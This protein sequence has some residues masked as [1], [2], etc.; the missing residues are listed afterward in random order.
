MDFD[1][2]ACVTRKKLE[3]LVLSVSTTTHDLQHNISL[4]QSDFWPCRCY[5]RFNCDLKTAYGISRYVAWLNY[6]SCYLMQIMLESKIFL[7]FA[8]KNSTSRPGF[9]PSGVM[10]TVLE[11]KY[12]CEKEKSKSSWESNL[13]SRF[14]SENT[15]HYRLVVTGS[16]TA[17]LQ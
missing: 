12:F 17:N 4:A 14:S 13:C 15:N 6:P 2:L 11:R 1:T 7:H 8:N 10:Q 16:K 5:L 9:E 3:I